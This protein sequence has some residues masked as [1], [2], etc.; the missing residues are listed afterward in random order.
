MATWK[1][2]LCLSGRSG[3]VWAAASPDTKASLSSVY[4]AS[5]AEIF[6]LASITSAAIII[7]KGGES[8]RG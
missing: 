1:G 2:Q 3:R 4:A 7:L 6:V 5:E 8:Q